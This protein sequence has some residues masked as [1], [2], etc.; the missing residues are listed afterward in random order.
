MRGSYAERPKENPIL[1][2]LDL[3]MPKLDGIQVI[4]EIK[5]HKKT[6][7]IPIVILTSSKENSDLETCYKLGANAYVVKPVQFAEFAE[8]IRMIGEFWNNANEHPPEGINS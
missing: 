5:A 8:K 3:K 1:I 2:I 4:K 6:S 7:L